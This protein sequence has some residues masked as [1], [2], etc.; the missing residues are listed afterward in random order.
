MVD[1][2]LLKKEIDDLGISKV[3]LAEKCNV[4]TKTLDNWLKRPDSMKASA[5]RA[6]ADALRISDDKLISIFFAPNAQENSSI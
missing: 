6:L 4:S 3:T 2:I 1:S 5:C